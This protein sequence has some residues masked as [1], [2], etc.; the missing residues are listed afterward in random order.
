MLK[1]ILKKRCFFNGL[2][3]KSTGLDA[4]SIHALIEGKIRRATRDQAP[5]EGE[6][7]RLF[8][9]SPKVLVFALSDGLGLAFLD[10]FWGNPPKQKSTVWLSRFSWG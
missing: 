5:L 2:A 6:K 10:G 8:W 1:V 9:T 7:C 4:L 3:R